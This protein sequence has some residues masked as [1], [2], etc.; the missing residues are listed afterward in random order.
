MSDALPFSPFLHMLNAL[1]SFLVLSWYR[2]NQLF[3]K[4]DVDAK[5]N[6]IGSSTDFRG[7]NDF[8]RSI[9]SSKGSSSTEND[10]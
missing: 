1:F 6:S 9:S 2:S 3:R 8:F 7:I 5:R 4:L 10:Y